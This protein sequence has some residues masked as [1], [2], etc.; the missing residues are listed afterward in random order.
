M[1]TPTP[2]NI[3]DRIPSTLS[4]NAV[5]GVLEHEIG[6]QR[7][8]AIMKEHEETRDFETAVAGVVERYI[9][10]KTS[11]RV[12]WLIGAIVLAIIAALA[13]HFVK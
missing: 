12:Y 5:M 11:E 2:A 9:K 4:Q 7:I 3:Q 8:L 10:I 13:G 6:R 1:D